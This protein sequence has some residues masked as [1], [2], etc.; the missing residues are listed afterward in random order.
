MDLK[1]VKKNEIGRN[2]LHKTL[3]KIEKV[4]RQSG[5]D[6]TDEQLNN[7]QSSETPVEDW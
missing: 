3:G 1:D 2:S 7:G 4:M 5:Q 6:Q